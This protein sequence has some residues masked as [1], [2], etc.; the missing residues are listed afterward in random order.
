MLIILLQVAF[1]LTDHFEMTGHPKLGD[2]FVMKGYGWEWNG[3]EYKKYELVRFIRK[4][5]NTLNL[6]DLSCSILTDEKKLMLRMRGQHYA[7]LSGIHHKKCECLLYHGLA[8]PLSF[9]CGLLTF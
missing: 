3:T 2:I 4:F 1:V 6:E 7:T 5:S 9:G 8:T